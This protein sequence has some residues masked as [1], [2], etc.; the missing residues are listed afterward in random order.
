MTVTGALVISGKISANG[1]PG[2]GQCSGGGAG[3]SIWLTAGVISGNGTISANG[4]AGEP[5][6]GGGGGGGGGRIALYP[7]TNLFTGLTTAYGGAGGGVGGAGTIYIQ[8]GLS[9]TAQLVIDNGGFSGATTPIQQT[10]TLDLLVTNGAVA[11]ATGFLSSIHNLFVASNSV[12]TLYVTQSYTAQ[13]ML[14]VSGD[15]II[16]PGGLI[17]VDGEV[18]GASSTGQGIGGSMLISNVVTGGG[19]GYGGYGGASGHGVAGGN[20]YG[21]YNTPTYTGSSGGAGASNSGLTA[22]NRGGAGGGLLQMSVTGNLQLGGAISANGTA[23]VGQ[24]SGGGSG[25]GISLTAGILSG[26]GTISANGGAGEP[27][28]GG[29]GGG[30]GGRI[31]L[32]SATNLFTGAIFAH[33]GTGA[34]AGGAGTIYSTSRIPSVSQIV[35]DN[36]GLRG[37]N[38][39]LSGI[40]ISSTDLTITNGATVM[41]GIGSSCRN[42]LIASNSFIVVSGPTLTLFTMTVTGNATIQPTG[43]IS[44]DGSGYT[45]AETGPG[46]GNTFETN[47]SFTGAGGGYGGNGGASAAGGPGGGSYGLITEPNQSGSNGG[48][49]NGNS[50]FNFGGAGGGAVQLNITGALLLNGIISANGLT[51]PGEGSGGGSGG[52]IMLMVLGNFSGAGTISANGGNAESVLGGGGGGGRIAVT[53][54]SNLFTGSLAATGGQGFATGGAGTIYTRATSDQFGQIVVDGG[55]APGVAT[56]TA[57][58]NSGPESDFILKGGARANVG[59]NRL[60]VH[61]LTLSSNTVLSLAGTNGSPAPGISVLATATIQPGAQ[62]TADG[63]GFVGD[64]GTGAGTFA[65][66]QQGYMAGTGGTYGGFGG[67]SLVA[68]A[69]GAAYGS[70]PH[71]SNMGS[72]GGSYSQ[73]PPQPAGGGSVQMTAV[74]LD[75]EGSI[76]ANGLSGASEGSGGGSGGSIQLTVTTLTGAGTISAN[77]GAGFLPYSGGGGGGRSAIDDISN[78][79][80]GAMTARGGL[81]YAA[82]GAGRFIPRCSRISRRMSWWIMA[83]CPARTRCCPPRR[84]ST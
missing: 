54:R 52:G 19:G 6:L 58:P 26:N 72:G 47:N 67:A 1:N 36:G 46:G 4:G 40:N 61:N 20:T 55:G 76:S 5:S 12:I 23:G 60:I 73:Q 74:T 38:T 3:G 51:G 9:K 34:V 50:P 28:L 69:A 68:G 83:V 29:G 84:R 65:T 59:P 57:L 42:L 71:P 27:S 8:P 14:T 2:T 18:A 35:L 63:G 43:G 16:L 62:I 15:A 78:H 79:F 49:G 53:C 77:G 31:M 37:T 21:T 44:A 75:L 66:S 33:G 22:N 80:S 10:S 13:I 24:A 17:T 7:T 56:F 30:G 32:S 41:L 70:I 64:V 48:R 81:G 82:G 25:G 11:A 39:P 45:G